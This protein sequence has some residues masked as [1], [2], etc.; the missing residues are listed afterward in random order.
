MAWLKQ[1]SLYWDK[2]NRDS[3]NIGPNIETTEK[4]DYN[5]G[6]NIGVV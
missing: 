6:H 4:N 5:T 1:P 3:C 2:Q